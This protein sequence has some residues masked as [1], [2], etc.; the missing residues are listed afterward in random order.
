MGR[1]VVLTRYRFFLVSRTKV[2]V[3]FLG[4]VI[5]ELEIEAEV[6]S[7]QTVLDRKAG[8]LGED[9]AVV[10]D[11]VNVDNH[12][13]QNFVNGFPRVESFF[14]ECFCLASREV[15]RYELLEELLFAFHF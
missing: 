5:G 6:E 3:V 9:L 14:S 15:F 12:T 10:A 7:L 11:L 8:D 13:A 1:G 2:N 4:V